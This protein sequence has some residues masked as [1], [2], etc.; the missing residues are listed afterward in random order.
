MQGG[1]NLLPGGW[2]GIRI[3]HVHSCTRTHVHTTLFFKIK[4]R[5]LFFLH[6]ILTEKNFEESEHH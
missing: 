6:Q 1:Q 3:T 5:L 4:F 2:G